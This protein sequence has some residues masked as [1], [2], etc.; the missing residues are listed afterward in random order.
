MCV[1]VV[2]GLLFPVF[3]GV[4]LFCAASHMVFH[5]FHS[6]GHQSQGAQSERGA[7]PVHQNQP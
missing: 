5:H 4:C 7:V 6:F 3:N 2:T 1:C